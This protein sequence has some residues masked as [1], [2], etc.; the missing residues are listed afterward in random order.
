MFNDI[1]GTSLYSPEQNESVNSRSLSLCDTG[2]PDQMVTSA[3]DSIISRMAPDY[4]ELMSEAKENPEII[5]NY[6]TSL[7]NHYKD[8]YVRLTPELQNDVR[9]AQSMARDCYVIKKTLSSGSQISVFSEKNREF[10][11]KTPDQARLHIRLKVKAKDIEEKDPLDRL[12]S[13]L[14]KKI[15]SQGGGDGG[16]FDI[17]LEKGCLSLEGSSWKWHYD[18]KVFKKAISVCF[19][20][21]ENWSTQISDS[22]MGIPHWPAA[23]GFLY[24]A[25]KVYHRA[26]IPYDLEHKEL[27]PDDYRLF[28]R[29]TELY[30]ENETIPFTDSDEE[31]KVRIAK[32]NSSEN[33]LREIP[34]TKEKFPSFL[35]EMKEKESFSSR[36]P[37]ILD[38]IPGI[39]FTN[40]RED[41]KLIESAYSEYMKSLTT[42]SLNKIEYDWAA[43][44]ETRDAAVSS[45]LA[46]SLQSLKSYLTV[47]TSMNTDGILA[48][49]ESEEQDSED[50][51]KKSGSSCMVM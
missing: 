42:I 31:E 9:E 32:K 19:S 12:L 11:E 27:N 50:E 6:K 49:L 3:V 23:H 33:S 5:T 35:S 28:I 21:K 40:R 29:Y 14:S 22:K 46:A 43:A 1:T 30:K 39:E 16:S 38:R 37:T 25:L 26:P 4:L 15:H 36:E 20:N 10:N 34:E 24:N 7:Y 51:E 17:R 2:I 41:P 45:E 48:P 13:Q 8:Q 44:L 47:D 18:G